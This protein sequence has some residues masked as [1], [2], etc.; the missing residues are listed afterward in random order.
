MY[1]CTYIST[2]FSIFLGLI[3]DIASTY[4]SYLAYNMDKDTPVLLGYPRSTIIWV[5]KILNFTWGRQEMEKREAKLNSAVY[6]LTLGKKH[7]VLRWLFSF[8]ICS[9]NF[10]PEGE[11]VGTK[12]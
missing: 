3:K 1:I 11:L 6:F 2:V 12:A 5:W 7:Q 9:F 8:E 4:N 10:R